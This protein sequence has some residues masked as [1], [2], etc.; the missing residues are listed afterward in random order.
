MHP[1]TFWIK[2]EWETNKTQTLSNPSWSWKSCR[3]D[4]H[5]AGV[6]TRALVPISGGGKW[7]HL[8]GKAEEDIFL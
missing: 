8:G 7:K 5:Q 4:R 6:G 2:V 1:E 3:A